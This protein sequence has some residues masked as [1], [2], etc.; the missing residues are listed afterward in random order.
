MS[1]FFFQIRKCKNKIVCFINK[2]TCVI[3]PDTPNNT[4]STKNLVIEITSEY[5]NQKY[6]KET[7]ITLH[8]RMLEHR[9]ADTNPEQ[10]PSNG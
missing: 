7:E 3:C 4:C 8:N 2:I 5:C 10:H 9:R 1:V 6:T